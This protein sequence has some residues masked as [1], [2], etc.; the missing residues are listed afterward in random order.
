M[1][2]HYDLGLHGEEVAACYL[3]QQGFEVLGQRIRSG[4]SDIDLVALRDGVVHFIEVKTRRNPGRAD[5]LR[6]EK[7][8]TPAKL[9]HMERAAERHVREYNLQGEI[10]LDLLAVEYDQT[11]TASCRLY[12]GVNR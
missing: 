2:K 4:K 6:P 1:A 10:S 7:A 8:L 9:A 11:D 3:A 5:D 12:L